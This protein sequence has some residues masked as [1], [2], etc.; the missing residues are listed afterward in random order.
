MAATQN[1]TVETDTDVGAFI[2][3]V[4][5]FG[6]RED[7]RILLDLFKRVTGLP[8]KMWG[9]SIIGFGSYHYKYASGREGDFLRTGFSPR[10]QN[11]SIYILSGYEDA[12]VKARRDAMLARLGKHK[13]AKACLYITQ[14]KNIDL[15]VLESLL[16]DDIAYMNA[17][18]PQ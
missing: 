13:I 8:P 11:M 18:Y 2:D 10:K 16:R 12:A 15:A 17:K 7:A 5:H 1:K 4:E 6:R 9:S 14:L 3:A